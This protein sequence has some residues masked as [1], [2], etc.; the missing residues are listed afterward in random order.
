MAL[1]ENLPLYLQMRMQTLKHEVT[2]THNIPSGIQT[3]LCVWV[4]GFI[5]CVASF[6]DIKEILTKMMEEG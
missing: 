5:Q 3:V 2:Y 4:G 6:P 1:L